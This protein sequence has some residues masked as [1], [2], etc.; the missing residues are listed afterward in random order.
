MIGIRRLA[1][2]FV[3]LFAFAFAIK[4]HY[5]SRGDV[6][7][8]YPLVSPD[9]FDWYTEGLYL[10]NINNIEKSLILPIL[11][12]PLFVLVAAIDSLIGQVIVIPIAFALSTIITYFAIIWILDEIN[13]ESRSV[14]YYS[15][16][17]ALL[18]TI[19]PVN[20]IK[21]YLLSDSLAVGLIVLSIYYLQ[22]Y[23]KRS[24]KLSI[25][26]SLL[27]AAGASLTQT[28]S[29]IPYFIFSLFSAFAL[30]KKEKNKSTI[31]LIAL[32]S[33]VILYV[34]GSYAWRLLLSHNDTPKNFGLLKFEFGMM[35]FYMNTWTYYISVF[36]VAFLYKYR[37]GFN[38]IFSDPFK[39]A[40]LITTLVIAILILFYQWPESRFTYYFWPWFIIAFFSIGLKNVNIKHG[41]IFS[42]LFFL[43]SLVAVENPW[44][45]SLKSASLNY[46]NN[47][48]YQFFTID[49]VDRKFNQCKDFDCAGNE[50]LNHSD[51]Y[52]NSVM[53]IN[54]TIKNNS[55]K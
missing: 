13:S 44:Q 30:Y 45:P 49:S 42:I 27:F 54:L 50:F 20:F 32:F 31:I 55:F 9:G 11:R 34:F 37:S 39:F 29:I 14:D 19:F 40:S 51:V 24:S 17:I 35:V 15:F 41:I 25:V 6:L 52:V 4:F 10:L 46:R 48:A 38:L 2:F 8:Y 47:W 18:V 5:L 33:V 26:L 12:P 3:I 53:R 23:Y 36:V 21:G 22:K 43:N 28:Y 7:N 1:N 16:P